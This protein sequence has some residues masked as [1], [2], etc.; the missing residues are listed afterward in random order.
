MAH[1][2][3]CNK[4]NDFIKLITFKYRIAESKYQSRNKF[5][6]NNFMAELKIFCAI[7]KL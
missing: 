2:C 3:I 4:L 5:T 6:S 7:A 1:F